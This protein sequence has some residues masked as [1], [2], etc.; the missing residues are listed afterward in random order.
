MKCN[1]ITSYSWVLHAVE[2][3]CQ[4]AGSIALVNITQYR[5]SIYGSY[6]LFKLLL[7]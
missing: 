1:V 7:E 3:L 5:L 6:N 2:I 4:S